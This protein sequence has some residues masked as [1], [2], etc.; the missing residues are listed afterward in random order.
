MRLNYRGAS[1]EY[2]TSPLEAQESDVLN[3]DAQKRCRTLQENAYP[4]TYR[5]TR[6]TTAQVA[7]ALSAP[8]SRTAQTLA[9][10]GVKYTR[11][12]DGTT[13]LMPSEQGTLEQV[14]VPNTTAA[15]LKEVAR[16]HQ[17]NIRRNL[18]R[19]LQAA[20]LRG[21]QTLVSLLE[22]ESKQLAL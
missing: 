8:A 6:Y 21:D 10:R 15:L 12:P 4:L 5:G 19:R 3:R 2:N 18:E 11:Q 1:Y 17:D 13:Q 22:A 7:A 14:T 20:K 9:Y 16:V